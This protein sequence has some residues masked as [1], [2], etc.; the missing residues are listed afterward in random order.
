MVYSFLIALVACVAMVNGQASMEDVM[1]HD[2]ACKWRRTFAQR[3][4]VTAG[5]ALQ[6]AAISSGNAALPPAMEGRRVPCLLFRRGPTQLGAGWAT[7][8]TRGWRRP[9][10]KECAA[11]FLYILLCRTSFR[12]LQVVQPAR[13][14]VSTE[15]TAPPTPSSS[16]VAS[17]LTLLL[18]SWP[19]LR[20]LS[21]PS[22]VS[23]ATSFSFLMPSVRSTQYCMEDGGCIAYRIIHAYWHHKITYPHLHDASI[24]GPYSHSC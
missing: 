11:H 14:T 3:P 23:P 15:P 7:S 9:S 22:D 20:S 21:F 8:C 19:R 1:Q 17:R 2:E 16:W 18:L 13:A 12:L 4:A 10:A 5:R 24:P 6:L